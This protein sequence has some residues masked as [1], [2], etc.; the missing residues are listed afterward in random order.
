M[1]RKLDNHMHKI[2]L[3]HYVTSH[4][5]K[6]NSKYFKE[7]N[8]TPENICL[9]QGRTLFD[10]DLSSIFLDMCSQ[11]RAIKAKKQKQMSLYQT[12]VFCKEKE[13]HQQIEKAAY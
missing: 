9:L 7:L 5:H 6:I 3:D 12:K 2:K 8:I 10:I 4:T 13:S 11:T 1:L